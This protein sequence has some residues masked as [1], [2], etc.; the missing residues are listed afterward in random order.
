MTLKPIA[1]ALFKNEKRYIP[2]TLL[3]EA[4]PGFKTTPLTPQFMPFEIVAK[5]FDS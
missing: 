3:L 1:K 2:V 5:I 4:H